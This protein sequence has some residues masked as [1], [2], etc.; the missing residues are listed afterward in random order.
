MKIAILDDYQDVVR[1]LDCFSLLADHEVNVYNQFG[2]RL[3]SLTSRLSE[4]DIIIIIRD[5]TQITAT[6]LD[7]LPRLRLICQMGNSI[8]N[9]D[10][11]ACTKRQV[12]VISGVDSPTTTAEFTW[13]LI[14]AAQR[15]IPQ[16][17]ANLKQGAWQ[18]AGLKS[19][20]LPNNFGIGR[21]LSGQTIGIW[22]FGKI[23][24]I[25]ASYATAFGMQ[26]SI[27][28]SVFSR[29]E[30]KKVGYHIPSSKKHFFSDC[31]II[32]IHLRLL[33]ET[34]GIITKNDLSMMKSSSLFVNTSHAALIEKGALSASLAQGKP[35]M[36]AVDVYENEPILQGHNLLRMENAVCTPHIGYVEQSTYEEG[37]SALFKN[38]HDFFSGDYSKVI[39]KSISN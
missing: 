9:I 12:A 17:I 16:Y 25:I 29:N 11:Q 24:K 36:A 30:A 5:R 38:I 27:W 1:K 10:L 39:N 34:T 32:S 13:G 6:L 19:A 23:G 37:F 2:R 18:Q 15:R 3:N 33:P 20:N 26:V 7:R 4:V 22:G 31:D 28:G 8:T 35:G 21:K 14:I